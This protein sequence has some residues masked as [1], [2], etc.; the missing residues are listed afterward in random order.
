MKVYDCSI[1]YNELDLLDIRLHELDS[2]VDYFVLVEATKTHSGHEKPLFYSENRARYARFANRIVH[3][4]VDDM[5]EQ[6]DNNRWPPEIHQRRCIARGLA[7]CEP[8]DIILI[9]D[10]DE[11]PSSE[12]VAKMRDQLLK[13]SAMAKLRELTCKS[14]KTCEGRW[15]ASFATRA[16]RGLARLLTPRQRIVKC[17]HKHFEYYLN[18]Y[19][20]DDW[21]GTTFIR[22]ST[23]QWVLN[24]D[25]EEARSLRSVPHDIIHGGWHFSY[26]GDAATIAQ[27]IHSFTHS[28][29]DTAKYTDVASIKVKMER[30]ENLF[31]K[32]GENH[33][34]HYVTIDDSWP[35]Y[36]L[37]NKEYFEH[38]IRAVPTSQRLR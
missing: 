38:F 26:L 22:F 36:V 25:T 12:T 17:L 10:A 2:V 24:M 34:V 21:R 11:I 23:L 29:F 31:G 14:L 28:E 9:S 4:V 8:N 37:Q 18:G 32:A 20:T 35:R 19:V 33:Q 7:A 16:C 1:F 27:K 5:P 3:I 13:P 30:G 15:N 6:V